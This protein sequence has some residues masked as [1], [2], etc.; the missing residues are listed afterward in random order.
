MTVQRQNKLWG[1][2]NNDT[3]VPAGG[4]ICR[5]VPGYFP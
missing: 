1:L 5:R 4:D 3:V 2:N